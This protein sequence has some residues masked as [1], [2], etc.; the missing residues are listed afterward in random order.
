MIYITQGGV[1]ACMGMRLIVILN[2]MDDAVSY[3]MIQ[4]HQQLHLFAAV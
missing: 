3:K 4:A 2:Y 1:L